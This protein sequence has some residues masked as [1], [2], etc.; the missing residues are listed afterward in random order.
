MFEDFFYFSR[1]EKRGIL[2][3]V[4]AIGV[5]ALLGTYIG[6]H[7]GDTNPPDTRHAQA[8]SLMR[9]H[10]RLR[11]SLRRQYGREEASTRRH[12]PSQRSL[13]LTPFPFNPNTA[14]SA[15]IRRLGLPAF[16]AGN[17]VK[18]RR[19]GGLFRRPEEFRKLYGLTDEQFRTLLPYIEIPEETAQR[20]KRS[21]P[22]I[23]QPVAADSTDGTDTTQTDGRPLADSTHAGKHP[24]Q[25]TP[26]YYKY[27][28]GTLVDLNRADTTEL[29]KIPGVGSVISRMIATYRQQLG[30][31]YSP[32]QLSEIRL[33]HRPLQAWLHIDTAAIRRI[34]VNRATL[35]QLYDHPYITIHHAKVLINYR[36]K[37]GKIKSLKP[38]ALY[39]EFSKADL[40]RITPY[41]DFE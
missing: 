1:E 35:K 24:R 15:T 25:E 26:T 11:D 37:E 4:A 23:Y 32:E 33:D 12:A 27:P 22:R 21:V 14:D 40:E 7:T 6:G 34:P 30:G 17:L 36:N 3:L 10:S 8:D 13:R 31:F 19:A 5:V 2:L 16:L 29:K 41:L 39:D 18:Y 9:A 20:P 38:F 28:E